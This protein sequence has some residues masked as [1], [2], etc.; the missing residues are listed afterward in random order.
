M[1]TI[2]SSSI[3]P[4]K[5]WDEFEDIMLSAAK[6]RWNSDA[7]FR[8][9][10]TGQKQDGVDVYGHDDEDRHIGVQCKNTIEGVSSAILKK[11]ISNAEAFRPLLDRL[12]IA[13]TA[14]RDASLQKEVRIISAERHTAGK[15]RIDIL[16]WDDI[17][18][19]LAKNDDM[20]F[21][22]YPQFRGKVDEARAHDRLLFDQITTLLRSDGVIGFLDHNNMAGFSF[23]EAK[24]DPLKEFYYIWNQPE[25]EFLSPELESLRK[26][27][28]QKVA[29]YMDLLT[30]ETFPSRQNPD[31]HEV[32]PEWELENPE[33]FDR[34]V[35][36]FHKLAGE[37][38]ALHRDLVRM[39]KAQ[40]IGR[41]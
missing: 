8:N 29:A 18:H 4:P 36:M 32:P 1:P 34:A 7:F 27:L 21:T 26:A 3:P 10:R 11:E 30:K 5:S 2:A 37:I 24:F 35:K 12:C 9:G 19:D 40:L 33:R 13:T 41:P 14:K 22:H 15:F 6:L 28:W 17:C 31:R 25:R 16:F 38:V 39:G 23:L 20:F